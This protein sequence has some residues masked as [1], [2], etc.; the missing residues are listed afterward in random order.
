MILPEHVSLNT[1]KHVTMYNVK[2]RF[3]PLQNLVKHMLGWWWWG[4]GSSL[5][6]EVPE[7]FNN[8]KN[9]MYIFHVGPENVHCT[10]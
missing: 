10:F 3:P 7:I 8:V 5:I 2:T 4:V 9:G 6:P 1:L